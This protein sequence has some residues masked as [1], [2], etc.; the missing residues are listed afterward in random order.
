VVKF[1]P[2]TPEEY[3]Q[4]G[5]AM[6]GYGILMKL[7]RKWKQNDEAIKAWFEREMPL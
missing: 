1:F 7:V 4:S 3:I 5:T 6:L 2:Q